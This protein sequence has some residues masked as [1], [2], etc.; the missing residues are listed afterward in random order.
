MAGAFSSAGF[1][2]AGFSASDIT[3]NLDRYIAEM[4]GGYVD[5]TVSRY[6]L[7]ALTVPELFHANL[8]RYAAEVLMDAPPPLYATTD[9]FVMEVLLSVPFVAPAPETTSYRITA[10]VLGLAAAYTGKHAE[11]A[12]AVAEVLM[13]ARS[14]HRGLYLPAI[15][16]SGVSVVA[17][18]TLPLDT[19]PGYMGLLAENGDGFEWKW[20]GDGSAYTLTWRQGGVEDVVTLSGF[21]GAVLTSYTSPGNGT[22]VALTSL[23]LVRP[24]GITVTGEIN[25]LMVLDHEIDTTLMAQYKAYINCHWTPGCTSRPTPCT[26]APPAG[27]HHYVYTANATT[28]LGVYDGYLYGPVGGNPEGSN[29]GSAVPDDGYTYAAVNAA[30]FGQSLFALGLDTEEGLT[31]AH[32]TVAGGAEYDVPLTVLPGSSFGVPWAFLAYGPGVPIPEI[33]AGSTFTVDYT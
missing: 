23:G 15:P 4:L 8:D 20:P 16:L 3:S 25:E 22:P 27:N 13:D 6:L 33:V 29:F 30:G 7:D 31:N 24:D 12:R 10:E 17:L 2:S 11:L 28:I 1:S 9:R 14:L 18:V 5:T 19:G 26:E 21:A 32:V